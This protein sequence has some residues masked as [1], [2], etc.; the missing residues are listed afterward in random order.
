[1][2]RVRSGLKLTHCLRPR[3]GAGSRNQGRVVQS[4]SVLVSEDPQ[5][6]A[7]VQNEATEVLW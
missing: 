1:M 4:D 6:V 5:E 3:G 7:L 2:W